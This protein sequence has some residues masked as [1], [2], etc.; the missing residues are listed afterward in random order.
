MTMLATVLEVQDSAVLVFDRSTSQEV[1]VHGEDLSRFHEQDQIRIE[2]DGSMTK[3]VPPQ[4][5]AKEITF[6]ASC[7]C[8]HVHSY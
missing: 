2:F 6:I 4:I 5:Y 7:S 1:L 8:G 3:S